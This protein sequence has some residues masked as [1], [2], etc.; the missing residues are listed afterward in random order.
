MR[1]LIICMLLLTVPA[2]GQADS[3]EPFVMGSYGRLMVGSD[4]TGAGLRPVQVIAHGPRLLE[5]AYAELDFAYTLPSKTTD[6]RF[7]SHLTLALGESLFHFNGKFSAE[8]AVRNFYLEVTQLVWQGF[9]VWAGSRMH[10]GDDIYLLDFWPLDEQNTVGGGAQYQIGNSIFAIHVGVNRLEDDFQWQEVTVVAEPFGTREVVFLDR[11]RMVLT[12]RAEHHYPLGEML[13]FKGVLYSEW[14]QVGAGKKLDFDRREEELPSDSGVLFGMQAG[15]SQ[16]GSAS[17]VNVFAR[18][19]Q[20]LAAFDELGV[21]HGLNTEKTTR[22]AH[23]WV[24]GL[25][26]NWEATSQ[27]SLIG[28]AYAREIVDADPNVFDRDDSWEVGFALRPIWYFHDHFQLAFEFNGQ[29][30]RP[31]GIAVESGVQDAPLVFQAALMPT[32]A[33]GR[34]SFSRPHLRLIYALSHLNDDARRTYAAIDPLRDRGVQHFLG[35]GIEWWWNS[36]RYEARKNSH[37]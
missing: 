17:F 21:P 3:G 28:G 8:M 37:E 5:S 24:L 1:E 12:A 34:G 25:S 31:N 23:E 36:S 13:N 6:T 22:G 29:Y 30:L 4:L 2:F 16:S 26:G 15:L 9:S 11:Q 20:G 19:G 27:F 10:R 7:T 33:L 14:H 35:V 32:I 18:Y